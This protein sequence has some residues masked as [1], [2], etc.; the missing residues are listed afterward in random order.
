MGAQ[1]AWSMEHGAWCKEPPVDPAERERQS[2][3]AEG[4]GAG[5]KQEPAN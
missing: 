4:Q 2:R 1:G 5:K 3:E